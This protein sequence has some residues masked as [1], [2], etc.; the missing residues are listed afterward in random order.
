MKMKEYVRSND[1]GNEMCQFDDEKYPFGEA[2]KQ[3]EQEKQ[4]GI[5]IN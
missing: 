3:V 4:S 5:S 2:S 1:Y